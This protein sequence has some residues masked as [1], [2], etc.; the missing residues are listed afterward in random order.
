MRQAVARASR[1]QPAPPVEEEAPEALYAAAWPSEG[2]GDGSGPSLPSSPLGA[3]MDPGRM[4]AT[5][6]L[7]VSSAESR[8]MRC[9]DR[10]YALYASWYGAVDG[11]V[12]NEARDSVVIWRY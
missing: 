2:R 9:F 5:R 1:G 11:C 10:E 4:T 6:Q 12:R 3:G 8:P 7:K